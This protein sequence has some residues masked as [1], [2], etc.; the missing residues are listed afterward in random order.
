MGVS[1]VKGLEEG[2]A[3]G[4]P[5]HNYSVDGVLPTFVGDKRG[6]VRVCRT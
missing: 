3:R 5:D 6:V 2:M 1:L 4:S